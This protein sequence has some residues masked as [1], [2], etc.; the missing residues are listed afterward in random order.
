M[1]ARCGQGVAKVNRYFWL[2]WPLLRP[3]SGGN[4]PEIQGPWFG[5]RGCGRG[6]SVY[7]YYYYYTLLLLIFKKK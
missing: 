5:G 3:F 1:A 4:V 2:P 6:E 7:F